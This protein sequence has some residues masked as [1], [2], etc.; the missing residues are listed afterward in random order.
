MIGDDI[1]YVRLITF[2][3]MTAQRTREAIDEFAK[4][5]Y[6]SLIL[7]LRNN[8]GG[9]LTSAVAVGDIFLDGGA[10]V[11][12]KSR[13]PNQ[14]NLYNATKATL[15]PGEVPVIV[16]INRGSASASEIV[17]GALKDRSRGYLVGEKSY[18]KGSVQQ[19]FP[20]DD[21]NTGFKITTSRYYTP[22]NVNIDKVGIPPDRVVLFPPLTDEEGDSYVE[23][24]KS[25]KIPNWVEAHPDADAADAVRFSSALQEEYKLPAKLINRFLRDEQNRNSAPIFDLEYDVQ[26]IEAVNILRT[27]NFAALMRTTK[28]LKSLQDATAVDEAVA[29][30]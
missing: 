13:L 25:R 23:L 24:V 2:S 22:S 26:L 19:V 16:L 7:D 8:Y 30:S 27:E 29:A 12:V 6:R 17:A 5:G 11:S 3:S 20:I 28:T 1:G 18:G 9:L 10:V 14:S 15:V 21:G 4:K